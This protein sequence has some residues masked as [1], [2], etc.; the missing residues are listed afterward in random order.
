MRTKT[1]LSVLVLLGC[2]AALADQ[3]M[4]ACD[5]YAARKLFYEDHWQRKIERALSYIPGAVVS[6]EVQLS[7]EVER[8]TTREEFVGPAGTEVESSVNV[9]KRSPAAEKPQVQAS[10]GPGFKVSA[11]TRSVA[12]ESRTE[13]S[14]QNKIPMSVTEVIHAGLTPESVRVSV[15][16]PRSY[17]AAIQSREQSAGGAWTADDRQV[18]LHFIE[19]DA[20]LQIKKIVTPLLPQRDSADDSSRVTVVFVD[21]TASA[22]QPMV[23]E[24]GFLKVGD[25]VFVVTDE[26]LAPAGRTPGRR[27]E[28]HPAQVVEVRENGAL[29]IRTPTPAV[30]DGQSTMV[31]VTGVVQASQVQRDGSVPSQH[32]ANLK[33]NRTVKN[34]AAQT[35]ADEVQQLIKEWEQA[36]SDE[37]RT[38]Q[39]PSTVE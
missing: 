29:L 13:E 18:S 8:Y 10:E 9:T 19:E 3:P 31:E 38:A 4:P 36:W 7:R 22:P 33:I 25:K 35:A 39:R 24:S 34:P 17:A 27:V 2:G 32:V 20:E 14:L 5:P 28:R 23:A 6:V 15:V 12:E 21:D 37:A 26:D 1:I 11:N 30:V 16:A